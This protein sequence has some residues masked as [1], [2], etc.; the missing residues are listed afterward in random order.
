MLYEQLK[1]SWVKLSCGMNNESCHGLSY[2]VV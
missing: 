2:H 1:L